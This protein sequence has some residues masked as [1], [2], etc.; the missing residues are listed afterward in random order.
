[1]R[2]ALGYA[3][4]ACAALFTG[5]AAH[6]DEYQFHP[7]SVLSLGR[8]FDPTDLT[9]AKVPCATFDKDA[10]GPGGAGDTEFTTTVVTNA[11]QLRETLNIDLRVAASYLAFKGSS[12]FSYNH[13][14]LFRSNSVNFVVKAKTE[15]SRMSYKNFVVLPAAQRLL[16]AHDVR[17]F[18]EMCGTQL[19]SIERDGA[20]VAAIVNIVD[21][22]QQ[23]S[24]QITASLSAQGGWGPVSASAKTSIHREMETASK[25]G[26]VL[27][28]VVSTGGPGFGA[29]SDTVK[30]VSSK[31]G[32]YD[33][34]IDTIAKYIKEFTAANAAPLF[35]SA[36]AFPGLSD[37]QQDIMSQQ[38]QD[39]L[40]ALVD[41]YQSVQQQVDS[42]R[43]I[44]AKRDVRAEVLSS[45]EIEELRAFLPT[46]SKYSDEIAATYARCKTTP[47]DKLNVCDPQGDAPESPVDIP[48]QGP[49][50][51]GWR[52]IVGD[53]V[54]FSSAKSQLVLQ[55]P[56]LQRGRRQKII[57][58]VRSGGYAP[59]ARHVDVGYVVKQ[60][61]LADVTFRIGEYS[62]HTERTADPTHDWDQHQGTQNHKTLTLVFLSQDGNPNSLE[63]HAD[64]WPPVNMRA[65]ANQMIIEGHKSGDA[66]F[67]VVVRDKFANS[68]T[69][70]L[71]KLSW[72]SNG[73]PAQATIA[74]E[75][76]ICSL[77]PVK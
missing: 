38:R 15:F 53:D 8:G 49:P 58:I 70:K 55:D 9:K 21:V 32:S 18:S 60:P 45:A 47:E 64:V 71:G 54:V 51:A 28:N 23:V 69:F 7:Q 35:Y 75:C 42:V 34:I 25:E 13:A 17:G 11:S 77:L 6:A 4:I 44:A 19:V 72:A 16:D 43:A 5:A 46:I 26:R 27:V 31:S 66:P 24:N 59:N 68:T 74:L 61:Y 36:S 2:F 40:L 57:D 1:M 12:T 67:T 3:A 41:I 48:P 29:L 62:S 73:D 20:M 37:A 14:S 10:L 22:D 52:V 76:D 56:E 39:K 50:I 30:A 63:F 33:A 65:Y